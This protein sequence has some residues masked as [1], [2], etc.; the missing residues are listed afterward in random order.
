MSLNPKRMSWRTVVASAA[1]AF[2]ISSV[3]AMAAWSNF[4]GVVSIANWSAPTQQWL[5]N[6]DGSGPVQLTSGGVGAFSA[7]SSTSIT[8]PSNTT[9]YTANTAYANAT[10]GATYS[11]FTAV[12]RA[13]S[14]QVLIPQIDIS[15][16]ENPATKLQGILW[17]FSATVSDAI[18]D[19]AA[20]NIPAADYANLNGNVEGFPFTLINNQSTATSSGISLTGTTYHAK[21]ASG[22]TTVYGM[23]Q[24]V[25]TYTPTSGE[26]MTVQLH[27]IGAN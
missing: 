19:N 3:A 10:S 6:S 23:V 7:I 20:F 18:E 16:D 27:T 2:L 9:Q 17:L 21:C 22:T 5:I 4:L 13:N 14:G 12:C 15:V 1:V 26:V 8:R 11:T 24:V 25:N